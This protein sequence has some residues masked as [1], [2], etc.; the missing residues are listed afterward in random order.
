[1]TFRRAILG[2]IA[3]WALIVAATYVAGEQ[4]EVVLLHT[5]DERGA[6]FSTKMWIVDLGDVTWVRVANPR[7][8]WYRRL[9]ANPRVELERGGRR[10]ARL[11]IPEPTPEARLAVDEAFAGKYG[12]VDRWYGLLVRRDAVPI[13]LV[14]PTTDP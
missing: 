3:V 5:R 12:L 2:S 7:R 13:R 10:E 11:A 4:T 1:M 8:A 9:L 14:P 6:E